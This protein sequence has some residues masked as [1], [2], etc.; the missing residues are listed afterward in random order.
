MTFVSKLT[1]WFNRR[2]GKGDHQASELQANMEKALA[3]KQEAGSQTPIPPHQTRHEGG[4]S[5]QQLGMTDRDAGSQ[6]SHQPQLKRS[7]VARSGDT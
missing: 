6:G 2:G 1:G 5:G 4:V 7:R 3:M